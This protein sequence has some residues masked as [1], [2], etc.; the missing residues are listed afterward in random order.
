MLQ[1]EIEKILTSWGERHGLR[2][3]DI[4]RDSFYYL[5]VGDDVGGKYEISIHKDESGL[6]KVHVWNH[7]K[8]RC[9]FSVDPSELERVLD[10]AYS[11]MTTWM[12]QSKGTQIF[13]ESS[14]SR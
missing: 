7:Q 2:I 13:A 3:S 14:S 12:K 5:D 4:Y 11:R 8:K 6:I 10:L 1:P 9:G